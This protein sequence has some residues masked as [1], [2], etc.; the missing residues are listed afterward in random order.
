MIVRSSGWNGS[1]TLRRRLCL[2]LALYM[3]MIAVMGNPQE[4]VIDAAQG[5]VYMKEEESQSDEIHGMEDNSISFYGVDVSWPMHHDTISFD[6]PNNPLGA[7]TRQ[8]AYKEYLQGCIGDETQGASNNYLEECRRFESD[9][10]SMNLRQ[11]A[12][13]QNYTHAGFAKVETPPGVLRRLQEVWDEASPSSKV[14]ERWERGNTYL[15]HWESPTYM[16]D[17]TQILSHAEQQ[18]LVQ[19]VQSVLEAWTQQS[20]ILT[21]LYGIRVYGNEA[22]LAPH[23]DR[24]PLVS[25]VIINVA[26][27][28][29]EPWVLEVIGH[30]GQATNI[31]MEPGDMV[32]YESHSVLHGRP[33]PLKG[34]YYANVFVHFEPV[35]HSFRHMQN[36]P[37]ETARAAY[38]RAL[39]YQQERRAQKRARKEEDIVQSESD[40]NEKGTDNAPTVAALPHYIPPDKEVRWRQQFEYEK[41]SQVRQCLA[42]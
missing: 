39:A 38:E 30:D 22:V 18:Q 13:S 20:L 33:F 23:V 21:S 26:Q 10:I 24:L 17:I 5:N 3:M 31:T 34:S 37:K 36:A 28:V 1:Q 2:V 35:G 16:I 40:D 29:E 25:S 15:N 32:L 27:D 11:P 6:R 41:E 4:A 7:D 14:L 9:R 12:N 19:A 8:F 42:R